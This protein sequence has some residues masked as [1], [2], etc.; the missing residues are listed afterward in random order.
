M[1][2]NYER[3][4]TFKY[5]KLNFLVREEK[6]NITEISIGSGKNNTYDKNAPQRC[7]GDLE[8]FFI[9]SKSEMFAKITCHGKV[10]QIQ[11]QILQ[12]E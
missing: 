3:V 5:N 9:I 8:K 4:N 6:Y 12:K 10:F 1:I 11:A 7:P 2:E